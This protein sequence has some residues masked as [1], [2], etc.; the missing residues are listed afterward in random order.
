MFFEGHDATLIILQGVRQA[1]GL[2]AVATVGAAAVLRMGDVALPGERHAQRAVNEKL[3]GRV[4]FVGDLADFL[5]VQLTC[6]Y[7]LRE[8]GLIEKLRSAQR[9][10]VGLGAGMQLDGRNVHVQNAEVLHDQCVHARVVELVNQLAGRFQLIVMQDGVDRGEDARVVAMGE[11]DQ[12]GDIAD[13]VAGVVSCAEAW[14]ANVHRVGAMQNGFTGDARVPCG[15]EQFQV[16]F[17]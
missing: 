17:G 7:Q 14:P 1:A 9:A 5:Q 16:V 13:L 6:Q 11:L 10:D 15:A 4:G 3:D 2:G 12:F 8:T